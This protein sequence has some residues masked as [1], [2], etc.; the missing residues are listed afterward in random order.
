MR[1]AIV[2]T[3]GAAI[4]LLAG[5]WLLF[6]GPLRPTGDEA[7]APRP[8]SSRLAWTRGAR[9]VYAIAADTDVRLDAP[10]RGPP[11]RR[12]VLNGRLHLRVLDFDGAVA[13]VAFQLSDLRLSEPILR[14][15]ASEGYT[16]A[17]PVQVRAI[18][19]LPRQY[20]SG[21]SSLP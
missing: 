19:W 4:A 9:Q 6:R 3:V 18:H 5:G 16:T 11:A 7:G 21:C 1:R 8:S 2:L 20:S 12:Q 10:G 14:A 13:K 17:T 15:V